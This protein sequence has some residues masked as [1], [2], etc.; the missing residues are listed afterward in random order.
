[1]KVKRNMNHNPPLSTRTRTS[2]SIDRQPEG[3][4]SAL[5]EADSAGA[6]PRHSRRAFCAG[7]LASLAS[8]PALAIEAGQRAPAFALPGLDGPVQLEALRGK[9]V[10]LDF[11]AS[12]CGPCKLS[13]PWLSAMQ[14]RHGAAGLRVVAVNVDRER[15]AAD[16]FLRALQ[17]QMT[18]PLTIAFDSAG[19]TPGRYGAKA[20]PTSVLIG[21]DGQVLLQHAGFRD[22]DKPALESAIAA[23]LAAVAS[24]AAGRASK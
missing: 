1:M 13:F 6:P 14:A 23:A 22:A 2:T 7:A 4:T 8:L 9:V 17:P 16:A 3:R 10:L 5:L 19:E 15:S 12:W 21:A 20:M 18:T 24:A 11:W